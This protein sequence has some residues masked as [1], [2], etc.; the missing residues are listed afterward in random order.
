MAGAVA[1]VVAAVPL[2]IFSLSGPW[3]SWE[4][5][6]LVKWVAGAVAIGLLVW[7]G[8]QYRTYEIRRDWERRSGS[9]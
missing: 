2:F 4:G 9:I 1:L 8:A 6:Q 5:E 7:A 3:F